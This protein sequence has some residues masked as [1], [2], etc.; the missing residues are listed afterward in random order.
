VIKGVPEI[1]AIAW[2]GDYVYV[3]LWKGLQFVRIKTIA[4]GDAVCDF[5]FYKTDKE[6]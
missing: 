6:A 4:N 1:A 3:K 2:E 5:R